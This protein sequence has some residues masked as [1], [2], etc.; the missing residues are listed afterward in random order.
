M[1]FYF[2]RFWILILLGFVTSTTAQ[3]SLKLEKD[4]LVHPFTCTYFT[5]ENTVNKILYDTTHRYSLQWFN[6]IQQ[7][8]V[9]NIAI[10]SLGSPAYSLMRQ[11]NYQTGFVL[12]NNA[13]E[14]Y[15]LKNE[16]IKFLHPNKPF[17]ELNFNFGA[18]NT[19]IAEALHG[20]QVSKQLSL[21]VHYRRISAAGAFANNQ[22]VI[23]NFSAYTTWNNRSNAYFN[24]LTFV[25]NDI[26]NQEFGGVRDT[27]VDAI[28]KTTKVFQTTNLTTA[29]NFKK[30]IDWGMDQV[31]ILKKKDF[32]PDVKNY[33]ESDYMRLK[34]YYANAINRF[35]DG[36]PDSLFFRDYPHNKSIIENKFYE[37]LIGGRVDIKLGVVKN[38]LQFN[39][40][41][42]FEKIAANAGNN[43]L[44]Y[45]R[46]TNIIIGTNLLMG[47]LTKN[48]IENIAFQKGIAGY[49]MADLMVSAKGS[50]F[51]LEKAGKL[52]YQYEFARKEPNYVQNFFYADSFIINNGFTQTNNMSATLQY[53]AGKKNQQKWL[54]RYQLLDQLIYLD[55]SWVYR[56]HKSVIH[57]FSLSYSNHIATRNFG[58][59]NEILFQMANT[60]VI[61]LVPY[62]IKTSMYYKSFW[63]KRNLS[64][65]FGGD[66]RYTG[67]FEMPGYAPVFSDFYTQGQSRTRPIPVLDVFVNARIKT[68]EICI[69]YN[70]VADGLLNRV[71][72]NAVAYPFQGR[73]MD[74]FLKWKFF[75]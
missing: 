73:G 74:L 53:S 60:S 61:P 11:E 39:P 52:I 1:F 66:I 62:W 21:G 14:I 31:L 75:N 38:K 67:A 5:A 69:K 43:E 36:K 10:G 54:V 37:Q 18:N 3:T 48:K 35:V 12:K 16:T 28:N 25:I 23:N 13:H 2:Q 32:D 24:I 26:K 58:W 19:L 6:F 46:G 57:L 33:H 72:F 20:Q 29:N 30:R 49:N 51:D 55:S 65:Q 71:N 34:L 63:F 7:E 9:E 40:Y 8:G 56:Q 22:S 59:K 17:V 44:N 4:T 42:I 15:F 47:K 27:S 50:L 64:I 45:Y 41:A 70:D 68:L